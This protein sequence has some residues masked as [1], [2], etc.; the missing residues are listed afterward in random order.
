[1]TTNHGIYTDTVWAVPVTFRD[2][3]G[4]T[5]D[6]S[7]YAYVAEL[8]ANAAVVFRFKSTGAGAT[9]GT[10]DLTSA[11]TGVIGFNATIAQHANVTAGI[12]RVHLKRDLSDDVWTAEGTILIGD[13]GA[14]ETYLVF[15][16]PSADSAA[17]ITYAQQAALSATTAG[18][19]AAAADASADAAAAS[20][21]AAD[22][23]A[24]AAAQTLADIQS[25]AI[26]FDAGS[27]ASAFTDGPS[28]NLGS[29]A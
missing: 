2:T 26:N 28:L 27:A 13:P 25:G 16:D 3:A 15:D 8:V 11:A 14:K 7:G 19:A 20:A 22:A 21:V 24:D 4:S 29:A 9:D 6:L 10:L 12:Y 5:I 23:S 17:A 18:I 1:M